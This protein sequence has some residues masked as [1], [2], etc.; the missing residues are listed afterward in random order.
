MGE[1]FVEPLLHPNTQ[2]VSVE[3]RGLRSMCSHEVTIYGFAV[4]SAQLDLV[5][6]RDVGLVLALVYRQ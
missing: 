4:I 6:A 1:E 5:L 3:R 2:F